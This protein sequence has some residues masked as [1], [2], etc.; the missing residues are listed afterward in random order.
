MG[1]DAESLIHETPGCFSQRVIPSHDRIV[2][3]GARVDDR[4][5]DVILRKKWV[6]RRAIKCELKDQHARQVPL[7]AQRAN[8]RRDQA[9]VF[10][11]ESRQRHL[12]A[13]RLQQLSARAFYPAPASRACRIPR[14]FPVG[15][16]RAKMINAQEIELSQLMPE[17]ID[18]PVEVF[19][20]HLIPVIN[21]VAP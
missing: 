4:V 9:K 11:D 6:V 8:L 15:F 1:R 2:V 5:F 18:P 7:I 21:G 20:T 19:Q 3:M 16:Q 12:P 10:S 13:H 14:Y 17:P